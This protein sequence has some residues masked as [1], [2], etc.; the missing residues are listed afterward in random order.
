MQHVLR[1]VTK[2]SHRLIKILFM[3]PIGRYYHQAINQVYFIK[4]KKGICWL[5]S[6]PLREVLYPSS[7][8]SPSQINIL[9]LRTS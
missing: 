5:E 1:S 6:G 3:R 7:L 8:R 2:L 9:A 4:I